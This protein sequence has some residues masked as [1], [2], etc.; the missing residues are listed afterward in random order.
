MA[1]AVYEIDGRDTLEEFCGV[2]SWVLIGGAEWGRNLDAF[3]E[4]L[5]GGFDPPAGG[6]T[7]L[8][9]W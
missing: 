5:R 9:N 2:V 6:F 4:M 1:K 7:L 3:N 8:P